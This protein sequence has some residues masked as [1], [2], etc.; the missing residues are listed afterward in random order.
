LGKY[1][2][3]CRVK[4]IDRDSFPSSFYAQEIEEDVESIN[5]TG[6]R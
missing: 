3:I 2:K 1:L 6:E 4:V 5:Q